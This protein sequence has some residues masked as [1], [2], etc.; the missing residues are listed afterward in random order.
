[1][2]FSRAVYYRRHQGHWNRRHHHAACRKK[3]E[4]EFA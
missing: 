3:D 1:M 4:I 2:S